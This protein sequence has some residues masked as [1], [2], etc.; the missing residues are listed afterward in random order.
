[1]LQGLGAIESDIYINSEKVLNILEK[2][3][4]ITIDE[5]KKIPDI[6]ENPVLILKSKNKDRGGKQ[7]TRLIIYGSV[8]GKDGRP[9]LSVLDLRPVENN[10]AINDMQKVSSVYTKD[11]NPVAFIENSDVVYADKKRTANL[12]HSIG[13]Q[14]PTELRHSGYIGSIS[15]RNDFVNIQ[16]KKFSDVFDTAAN[17]YSTQNGKKYAVSDDQGAEKITADDVKSVQSVGR[18]SVND[19]TSEDIKKTEGFARRYF[20][21]MGAKSPFFRA[22]FG[23]WRANDTSKITVAD[24]KGAA[25]GKIKNRDTGWDIQVSRKVFDETSMHRSEK[26]TSGTPYLDYINSIVENAVLLDS[27]AI[28]EN[29][30]K[31]PNSVMMH[32]LY[33]IADM[34]KGKELVK[35]YIE[36][37]N[38]VNSDGTMKSAYQLQNIE[39]QQSGVI[40]SGN[41]PSQITQTADVNTVSQLF[42]L[43]KQ[44]DKNFNPKPSSTLVNEN[45]T[46]SDETKKQLYSIIERFMLKYPDPDSKLLDKELREG[47]KEAREAIIEAMESI[48]R[49]RAQ[50]IKEGRTES[51]RS[52]DSAKENVKYAVQNDNKGGKYWEIDTEKGIFKGLETKEEFRDAAFNFLIGNRDNKVVYEDKNG[53]KIKFIRVSAEE[54]TRS[55]ESK[56]YYKNDPETFNKKMRL[57]PSLKD[58]LLNYSVEWQSK[59]HKNHALFNNNGFTNYRGRVRIDDTTFNYVVRAGRK[60]ADN[61][62]YDINL[63]VASYLPHAKSGASDIKMATSDVNSVSQKSETVNTHSMQN[64]KKYA[65]SDSYSREIDEW[66]KSGKSDNESFAL[67]ST[68]DVLQGLEAIESDIYMNSDKINRILDKHKEIT[69]AEIKKI[70][71]ILEDPV[72]ILKSQNKDRGGKQNTRL[73]IFGSV[74]GQDGRPVLSVLDLRPVEN[75]LAIN[76][77]QKVSSVY[78]KDNNPVA[79]IENSDVV[80]ADKKRTANLLHSIGFQMPTE[81]RQSGYIGSI[82]YIKRS[83]NIQGEKFSDVFDTAANTYSTQTDEKYAV[84]DEKAGDDRREKI[85]DAERGLKSTDETVRSLKRRAT[86]TGRS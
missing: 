49:E 32:S 65:V 62:F 18:K 10:L 56:G 71:E 60:N 59:D 16:G 55:E 53:E 85:E 54:F 84:S 34:G 24:R 42:N 67:G 14:M 17:T 77:M 45:G 28:P 58:L 79:F 63:E 40:G 82:S 30:A 3:K 43:V 44:K 21:E 68:G 7:N 35:L 61:I 74:K 11:N 1:M 12:L 86:N 19:F 72:L 78:T 51:A 76:D 25:R 47:Y 29:K 57:I 52:T 80:Y 38:D 48:D 4:E 69:V 9:V 46:S 66:Y 50:R 6:I 81:L 64:G 5:I 27:Y 36:E 37:I 2:H 15:Y 33:A 39:N 83:V 13:F 31:S 75:N 22:W 20:K 41:I 26:A 73:I 8:K 70:P 23:D